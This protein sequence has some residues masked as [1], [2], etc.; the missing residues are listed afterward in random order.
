MATKKEQINNLQIHLSSIRKIANWTSQELGDKVGVT[1]Q[2]ISNLENLKT[3]MTQTQYI[4][5]RAILDF[6]IKTNKENEVLAQVVELLLNQSDNFT[7]EQYEQISE[8][9]NIIA[10]TASG[11]IYGAALATVSSGLLAGVFPLVGGIASIVGGA[12]VGPAIGGLW[13][14]KILKDKKEKTKGG[15]T[16][17]K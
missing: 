9:I 1:K 10:A 6:E 13:L 12:A 11:G 14:A 7:E 16:N 3:T 8:K 4:A 15:S 5:I 2:T 17:D